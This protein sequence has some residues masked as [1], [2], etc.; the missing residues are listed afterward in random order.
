MCVCVYSVCVYSVCTVCVQC[1]CTVCVYTLC[2]CVCI[3]VCKI[4]VSIHILNS[5]QGKE[6][7]SGTRGKPTLTQKTGNIDNSALCLADEWQHRLCDVHSTKQ[8]HIHHVTK[9]FLRRHLHFRKIPHACIVHY[10]PQSWKKE[11]KQR[12]KL[13]VT[14]QSFTYYSLS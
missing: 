6:S 12:E 14:D 10:S 2:V 5:R 8:V 11:N 7:L 13:T 3:C 1:V 9:N 4:F